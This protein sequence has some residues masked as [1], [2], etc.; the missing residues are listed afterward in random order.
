MQGDRRNSAPNPERRVI[1]SSSENGL[2]LQATP[3]TPQTLQRQSSFASSERSNNS[4][5]FAD[6][7]YQGNNSSILAL[8]HV[9]GCSRD[10]KL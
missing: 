10:S 1:R 6:G 4:D 2:V 9:S 5:E 3:S 8:I 7:L